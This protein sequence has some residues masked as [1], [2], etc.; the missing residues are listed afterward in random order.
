M[1]TPRRPSVCYVVP[2][3]HLL[4]S[5]GP[6]RN[7][8]SLACGMS[9]WA[10]VTVAFRR[11]VES[12]SSEP[13]AVREIEPG[14]ALPTRSDDAAVR[15]VGYREFATYLG[16]VRRFALG[17]D[18]FDLVLEKSWLLTGYVSA[19]SARRGQPGIPVINVV[20]LVSTRGRPG[21][22]LRNWAGRWLSG[23]YLRRLPL[24]VAET[25][26]LK[27]AIARRFGVRQDRIEVIGLGVDRSLFR[28]LDQAA[29]R[30]RLGI[31]PHDAVLL[32]VGALDR[33]HD[34]RPVIEAMRTLERPDVRFHVVG[35][36]DLA[37]ALREAA[38]G[39][40]RIVFHGRVHHGEVPWYIAASDL[41]LAPYDQSVFADGEVSYA[42]LKVR[43]YLAGARPVATVP[44]GPLRSLVRDAE[45]G[46]LLPNQRQ[47]W[48]ELLGRTLPSRD[49]LAEMGRAAAATPLE[50][51]EDAALSF[52][53]VG[54]KVAAGR[55]QRSASR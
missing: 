44:S 20:P 6:T 29:A 13:F 41:C 53:S 43:E 18:A 16:A 28:P 40:R 4:P 22:A 25:A 32:Y 27:T 8:L 5:A 55:H 38:A 42:T 24:V 21:K 11:V 9:R 34:A 49:R 3:H 39:D 36:G 30:R 37:S 15:G 2:G 10:D 47:A 51:W 1:S 17:L 45:T 35:D 50:S 54:E 7:V 33:I 52:R 26:E 23:R 31:P 12:P 19:L 46:F 14:A 48:V